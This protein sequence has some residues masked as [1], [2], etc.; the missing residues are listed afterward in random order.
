MRYQIVGFNYGATVTPTLEF[1]KLTFEG[2]KFSTSRA[3][4]GSFS[5]EF[6][7]DLVT[8]DGSLKKEY[9][10]QMRTVAC[11][12]RAGWEK[13]YMSGFNDPNK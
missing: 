13:G 5:S 1:L 7:I 4:V 11:A 9:I 6:C 2:V 3:S 10:E 8:D 12:F